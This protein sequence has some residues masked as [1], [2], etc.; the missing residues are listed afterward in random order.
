MSKNKLVEN[1]M[2]CPRFEKCSQNLCPLDYELGLR[3]GRLDRD[4]C[5]Y[6]RNDREKNSIMP[7]N[8]LKFVPKQN[9][10]KLNNVSQK[11]HM[12]LGL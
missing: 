2:R 7:D 9:I 8:L 1:L 6:I 3:Y 11:R 5:K 4:K 12:E 10:S